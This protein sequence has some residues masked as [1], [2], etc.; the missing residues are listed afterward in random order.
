MVNYD[1]PYIKNIQIE[2][3]G[4]KKSRKNIKLK[5]NK[6]SRKNKTKRFYKNK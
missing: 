2:K 4:T 1:G 3:G 6:K 5:R